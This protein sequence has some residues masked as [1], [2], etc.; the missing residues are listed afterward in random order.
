MRTVMFA[1]MAAALIMAAPLV[2]EMYIPTGQTV[3]GI[4]CD[5][6]EGTAYHIHAHLSIYDHGRPVPVPEDVGRP[7]FAGCLYWLHTH[8]PDGIIHVESPVFRT[9]TLG[10]FFAIW[11]QPLSRTQAATAKL[12]RGEK[13]TVWVDGHR[14]TGDPRGIQ[15]AQHLDVTID[16]GSPAPKPTPFTAWN[17]L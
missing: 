6:I 4:R 9:F 13:M 14:Y 15:I 7:L 17:G 8:T 12:R 1:F 10:Q 3:Q 5:P 11:G 16:V 2:A